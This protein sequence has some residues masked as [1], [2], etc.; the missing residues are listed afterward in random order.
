MD[1]TS[2]KIP[3][4][5]LD[6]HQAALDSAKNILGESCICCIMIT[7]S[8]SGLDGNMQVEMHYEGDESLAA[9][10]LENANQVFE[11]RLSKKESK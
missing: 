7:C 1:K 8:Q 10:L 9:F 2:V 11:E 6:L 5:N 4:K 3:V